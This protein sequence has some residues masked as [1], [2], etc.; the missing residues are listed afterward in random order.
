MARDVF[1]VPAAGLIAVRDNDDG[2]AGEELVV[3]VTP[4]SGAAGAGGGDAASPFDRPDIFLALGDVDGLTRFD[5]IK[6]F[7]Q[8][9]GDA[10]DIAKTPLA[11][12]CPPLRELFPAGAE[13]LEQQ[14][15][16]LINVVIDSKRSAAGGPYFMAIPA[17]I[18]GLADI[19][20]GEPCGGEDGVPFAPCVAVENDR[21]FCPALD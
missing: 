16:A 15:A 6:H 11:V 12:G 9:V 14:V 18:M 7:G 17:L 20:E 21:L 5:G 10:A 8:P 1:S 3:V 2:S 19:G 4:F 13:H